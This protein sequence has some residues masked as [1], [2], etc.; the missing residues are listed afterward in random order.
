MN[1]IALAGGATFLTGLPDLPRHTDIVGIRPDAFLLERPDRPVVE[2]AAVADL[3]EPVGSES[4]L[5]LT[6]E[7]LGQ[8]IVASIPSRANIAEGERVTLFVDHT[9]LHP[10]NSGTGKRTG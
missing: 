4:H 10:F 7:G 1:F 5:H 2:I 6:V 9:D 3:V 8:T